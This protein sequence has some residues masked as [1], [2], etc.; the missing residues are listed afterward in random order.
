MRATMGTG[1]LYPWS[2]LEK[3]G[4]Y[5]LVLSSFKPYHHMNA[6]I[7][8]RNRNMR[9]R[10]KYSC[11]Q[12]TYGSIV[13]LAQVLDHLPEHEV[14]IL[15]GLL[16]RTTNVGP[17]PVSLG[18]RPINRPLTQQ[19]RVDRMSPEVRASNLPWWYDPKT[20]QLICGPL[21]KEPEL[22]QWFNK[23]FNPGA[24]TPYPAH[25]NLDENLYLKQVEEEDEDDGVP[26]N[27]GEDDLDLDDQ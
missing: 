13:M 21:I 24:E 18:N 9:G 11:T 12:T 26:I 2:T 14:E 5:F 7:S 1:E 22:S 4:D 3:V 10:M 15:E 23:Q 27:S 25:Y 17:S 6:T 19:E 8:V 20:R 16:A